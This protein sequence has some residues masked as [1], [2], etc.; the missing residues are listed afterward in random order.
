MRAACA[1]FKDD[2]LVDVATKT[3]PASSN[4]DCM[5]EVLISLMAK[6]GF[7]LPLRE[8]HGTVLDNICANG[9]VI[10]NLRVFAKP[11]DRLFVCKICVLVECPREVES[12]FHD[13]L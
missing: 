8:L 9:M 4:Q 12:R 3:R 7:T 6:C 1:F 5:K 11:F 10:L 13:S 2:K